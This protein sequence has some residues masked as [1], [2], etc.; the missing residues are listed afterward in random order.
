MKS[1]S[2]SQNHSR[3]FANSVRTGSGAV[4]RI[5]HEEVPGAAHRADA[6]RAQLAAQLADVHV[7]AALARVELAAQRS[8]REL[9]AAHDAPVG[10]REDDE[11]LELDR[12]Q[13]ERATRDP[14]LAR[15]EV[16]DDVAG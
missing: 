9:L 6:G 8:A 12:G 16:G 11:H 15:A 13:F 10:A 2:A 7:D 14:G 4:V 5:A 3:N 1:A